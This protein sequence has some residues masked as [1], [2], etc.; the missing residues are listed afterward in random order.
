MFRPRKPFAPTNNT[1]GIAVGGLSD[2]LSAIPVGVRDWDAGSVQC[3]KLTGG[4]RSI[5]PAKF[6]RQ[7]HVSSAL[8]VPVQSLGI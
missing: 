5:D 7:S 2:V 1:D 8:F 4:F 6:G 3:N